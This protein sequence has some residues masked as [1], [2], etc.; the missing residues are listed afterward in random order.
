MQKFILLK[1]YFE[2]YMKK[3]KKHILNIKYEYFKLKKL[4]LIKSFNTINI[5][6]YI[7]IFTFLI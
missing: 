5:I 6:I 4:K 1:L 3:D 7:F 2:L